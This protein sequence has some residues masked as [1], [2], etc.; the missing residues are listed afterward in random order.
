MSATTIK[1]GLAATLA[2][3]CIGL[4]HGCGDDSAPAGPNG[5]MLDPGFLEVQPKI[6]MFLDSASVAFSAGFSSYNEVPVTGGDINVFYGPVAPGGTPQ[7]TYEYTADGW[8]HIT[9]SVNGAATIVGVNDSMQF[10]AGGIA[11]QDPASADALD[12]R[13]HWAV[14]AVDQSGDFVNQRGD[15]SLVFLTL[16]GNSAT[17]AGSYDYFVVDNTVDVGVTT[18]NTFDFAATLNIGVGKPAI[19]PWGSGCPASG[20]V[21]FTVGQTRIITTQTASGT[22]VTNWTGTATFTAGVALVSL[23]NGIDNWTYSRSVCAPTQ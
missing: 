20:Q 1:R 23:S 10:T 14:T 16:T 15:V 5:S 17:L 3:A 21:S 19:G 2:L 12:Y 6:N 22:T 13:H 7:S 18:N 11:Q 8:H 9:L 4:V